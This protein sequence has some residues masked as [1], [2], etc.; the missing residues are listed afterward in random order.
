MD[1]D[2]TKAVNESLGDQLT[3]LLFAHEQVLDTSCILVGEPS[4]CCSLLTELDESEF[5]LEVSAE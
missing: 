1:R 2:Y 4:S 3:L 5:L